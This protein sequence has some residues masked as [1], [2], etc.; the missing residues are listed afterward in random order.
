[1]YDVE[2]VMPVYNEAE[3]IDEVVNDWIRELDLLGIS[4]RLLIL[5]DGSRDNTAD[6]LS[7]YGNNPKVRIINKKNSGHGPTILQGYHMAIQEAL[8]VFQG[9]SDNEISAEHFKTLWQAREKFDAVIGSR[10]DR[11]QPLA[12]KLVSFFSRFVVTLFY[13]SGVTDT[14]CAFRLLR[15]DI[16]K[17]ILN[18]LPKNMFAPN[19][20]ISGFLA[21]EKA[22]ILNMTVPF[23]NRQTGEVSIK[24]WKLLKAA[25]KSFVQIIQIRFKRIDTFKRNGN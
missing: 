23:R 17:Q 10:T 21:L 7:K 2:I 25:I 24:K 12:R 18:R 13:G 1:M 5:N 19:V 4:Y 22:R 9:D 11:H 3:C 15:S 16:L 8:W 20:A 14:N 6:V